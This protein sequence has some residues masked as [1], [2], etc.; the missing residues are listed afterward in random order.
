MNNA[1]FQNCSNFSGKYAQA[2][3]DGKNVIVDEFGKIY[4]V[5]ELFEMEEDVSAVMWG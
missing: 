2:V 3:L 4:N 5:K 1:G